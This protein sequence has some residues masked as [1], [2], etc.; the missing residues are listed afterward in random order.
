MGRIRNY[1]MYSKELYG[2]VG[3]PD[4]KLMEGDYFDRHFVI[5]GHHLGT[6][7]AYLEVKEDDRLAKEL[8][9]EYGKKLNHDD[10][11]ESWSGYVHCGATYYGN[12]YWDSEDKRMYV[13]WDYAHAGDYI[14]LEF[15]GEN[16]D[17]KWSF[18]EILMD[19]A[20]GVEGF[21]RDNKMEEYE[22]KAE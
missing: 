6:P 18:T 15:Y 1:K 20:H 2:N 4:I 21:E 11:Y 9:S 8:P 22:D 7:C 5:L 3:R 10:R 16:N 19:I 13:G 14:P 17:Y 12:A